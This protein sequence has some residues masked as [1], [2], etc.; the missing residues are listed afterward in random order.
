LRGSASR[1]SRL[2]RVVV[3]TRVRAVIEPP[4]DGENS[5][6]KVGKRREET[7]GQIKRSPV[8][9]RTFILD[10]CLLGLS[11][12]RN[13]DAL[14]AR[15]WLPINISSVCVELRRV[16]GDNKVARAHVVTTSTG[17]SRNIIPSGLSRESV[18]LFELG[19]FSLFFKV[20][21]DS[22]MD[23]FSGLMGS[24]GHGSGRSSEKN[25]GDLHDNV[26]SS[27]ERW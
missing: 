19:F 25:K 3:A 26:G 24:I 23:A 11:V 6:A 14:I 21:C 17:A 9:R 7:C 13:R 1:R 4:S 27:G 22:M 18:A 8:T 5:Y 20:I 16:E 2:R 15:I 12:V 10:S